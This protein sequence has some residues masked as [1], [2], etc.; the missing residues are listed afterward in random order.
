M[1][2]AAF[3]SSGSRY[4]FAS[5]RARARRRLH[6]RPPPRHRDRDQPFPV[7]G[8]ELRQVRHPGGVEPQMR[9]RLRRREVPLRAEL[10]PVLHDQPFQ[11]LIGLWRGIQIHHH[12]RPS[13]PHR[14]PALRLPVVPGSG[15]RGDPARRHPE[16]APDGGRG[17]GQTHRRG[18]HGGRMRLH[19]RRRMAAAP[20]EQHRGHARSAPS[21]A[22]S[23]AHRRPARS[24]LRDQRNDQEGHDIRHLDHRVDGRPGGVLERVTHRVTGDRGRVGL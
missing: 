9:H 22:E 16:S 7:R 14:E 13:P 5:A 19:H 18:L 17:C 8:E 15:F 2:S 6:P 24:G 23:A 3:R 12:R 21:G 20:P 11:P 1:T 4:S 10:L